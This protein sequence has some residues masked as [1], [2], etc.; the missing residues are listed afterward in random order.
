MSTANK[1]SSLES[2]EAYIESLKGDSSSALKKLEGFSDPDSIRRRLAILIDT[3]RVQDAAESIQNVE[4]HHA[5]IDLATFAYAF[6]GDTARAKQCLAWAICQHEDLLSQKTSLKFIAGSMYA[7]FLARAE[8]SHLAPGSFSDTE[9]QELENIVVSVRPVCNAIMSRGRVEVE[10]ESQLLQRYLD[11][12][13]LLG[14]RV[15]A[16]AICSILVTR[17][18]IP[19]R[20]GAAILQGIAKPD[21]R[22]VSRLWDENPKS[23]EARLLACMILGRFLNDPRT[24]KVRAQSLAIAAQNQ[25]EREDICELLYELWVNSPD[26]S[27]FSE[28]E[29]FTSDLLGTG[30][31]LLALLRADRELT[32]DDHETALAILEAVRNENDPRWLRS[33]ANAKVK[34]GDRT[35]AL[36]VFRRVSSIVA[37]PD[38]FLATA[39]LAKEQGHLEEERTALTRAVALDPTNIPVRRRLAMLFASSREYLKAAEQLEVL[40]RLQPGEEEV[41]LNL[42]VSYAFSG[43]TERALKVLEPKSAQSVLPF[44]LLK[45][46]C[47][48]LQSSGN[49]KTALDEIK[50]AR[51][52]YWDD[53]A[54][55]LMYM[56]LAYAA[57]EERDAHEALLKLQ[58]LREK[59]EVDEKLMRMVSLDEVREWLQDAAKRHDLIR[60]NILEGKF[61]WIMAAQIQGEVPYW[62]WLLKT[63]DMDWVWDDP[64]NRASYTV[65]STNSFGRVDREGISTFEPIIC[66][67]KGTP[68][69]VDLTALITLHSLGLL[70]DAAEFFGALY[71]PAVYL[72]EV[73]EDTR[74]LLPHQRSQRDAAHAILSKVTDRRITVLANETDSD[75]EMPLIDEYI[76]DQIVGSR[77]SLADLVNV[78]RTSGFLSEHETKEAQSVAHRPASDDVGL[79]L[80]QKIAIAGST[81]VTLNGLGLVDLVTREFDVHLPKS[82]NDEFVA[83]S[84]AFASLEEAHTKHTELWTL[85]RNDERVAF[86]SS[87]AHLELENEKSEKPELALAAMHVAKNRKLPLFAD[88]RV[89]QMLVQNERQTDAV[90]AFGT[91]AFLV[92]AFRSGSLNALKAAQLFLRLM[93]WRYRFLLMPPE[94][95]KPLA[96]QFR[97]NPPGLVMRRVAK[98]IHDCMSD[99]GLFAGLEQ[100]TPPTSVAVRLYQSWAQNVSEFIM[101]T[102]M[103]KSATE[104]YAEEFTSWAIAELL[105]SP[106][107]NLDERLQSKIAALTAMTVITRALIRSSHSIDFDRANLGLRS[108]ASALG[109]SDAEYFGIVTKVIAQTND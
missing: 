31:F 28:I 10:L 45:T 106:P 109:T 58:E 94:F 6:I 61:P 25:R 2:L 81:L 27:D 83:R 39:S 50:Q 11:V 49:V 22:I 60:Q 24:A 3:N 85:L 57:G 36:D 87:P 19:A 63:Q 80:G 103:D 23:F 76:G 90:I 75:G 9:R 93:E 44:S 65:Y 32:K 16:S 68:V 54:Y 47:Q 55:L 38:L 41:I 73:L 52:V 70:S 64:L 98:Y 7:A 17:T 59:G 33:F 21:A 35:E 89:C 84:R 107:R 101:D 74:K 26:G 67:S 34:A 104:A 86:V 96:D 66:P 72:S 102:W 108:I 5:W 46:R 15:E 43:D 13:Y 18:P 4:P 62:A 92:A 71:I 51:G 91:D 48:I 30:S 14:D 56:S 105:P 8:G 95:L 77:L 97:S 1:L 88:D 69:V 37:S 99:A 20:V 53:P 100:T 82:D 29:Q 78:L 42:A 12:I 40:A 79:T